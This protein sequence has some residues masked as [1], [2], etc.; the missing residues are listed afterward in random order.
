MAIRTIN[1]TLSADGIFPAAEQ[2][3]GLRGEH[4]ATELKFT[5][6]PQLYNAV[7]AEKG[8]GDRIVYR[9][10]CFD[11][12][13]NPFIGDTADL[14]NGT[15]TLTL[16][17]NLTRAGGRTRVHL[18]ISRIGAS[19]QAETELFSF[20]AR[21]YF[22]NV[23]LN[24]TA[25]GEPRA[26]LSALGEAAKTAAERAAQSAAAAEES[27][28]KTELARAAIE[29]GSTVIFDG[30]GTFGSVDPVFV[31]DKQLSAASENAVANKAVTAKLNSLETDVDSLKAA[32]SANTAAVAGCERAAN[33]VDA[34][35]EGAVGETAKA[36]Y[37]SMKLMTDMV[38]ISETGTSG[39]WTYRKWS[40]GTAEC[41]GSKAVTVT[42]DDWEAWGE[43]VCMT[44]AKAGEFNMRFPFSFTGI[45]MLQ[46]ALS[47]GNT[48]GVV[49]S[50]GG[51][52]NG[53]TTSEQTGF[54][55]ITRSSKL[56][57]SANFTM[58]FYAIGRYRS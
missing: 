33:K 18:I 40:D 47:T 46:R 7:M 42:P 35:P 19:E 26:S 22:E 53:A 49:M 51:V 27:Q 3:A 21:L 48:A 37:P 6:S 5:L 11:G 34:F 16:G 24:S 58:N 8:E 38:R 54:C 15:V 4:A 10:D 25:Y 43:F 57:G 41:W 39:V 1:Y 50:S 32:S 23:P 13:G 52:T 28:E 44:E 17:E 2:A 12:L 20:P 55:N 56:T 45:P 14:E 31:V 9:F 30:N 36:Q 29:N